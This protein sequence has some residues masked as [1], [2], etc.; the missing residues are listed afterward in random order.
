MGSTDGSY[1]RRAIA[2]SS[3]SMRR[4]KFKWSCKPMLHFQGNLCTWQNRN[5]R[6]SDLSECLT[7]WGRTHGESEDQI[8]RMQRRLRERMIDPPPPHQPSASPSQIRTVPLQLTPGVQYVLT[9]A[10][11]LPPR[12]LPRHTL[13]PLQRHSVVASVTPDINCTFL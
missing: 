1:P 10:N 13:S 12:R 8:A 11:P 5:A 9:V 3:G 2:C 7:V 4:N 6:L